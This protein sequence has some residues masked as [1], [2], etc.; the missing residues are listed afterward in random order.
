MNLYGYVGNDPLNKFDPFGEDSFVVARRLDSAFGKLSIGHAF[1]VTN[2]Q[3]IGD[4]NATVHSFGKLIN[5]NMGNITDST[6]AATIGKS[7]FKSDRNA[8]LALSRTTSDNISQINAPD[9]DVDNVVASILE[10][11]PYALNPHPQ[12]L[13][14]GSSFGGPEVV[15]DT[16]V[17]SSSGAFAAGDAASRAA[18]NGNVSREPFTLTLPGASASGKVGTKATGVHRVSGRIESNNLSE[19]GKTKC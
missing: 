3:F 4:P 6:R 15:G 8:W 17:N 1:V 13:R 5:G 12:D 14:N 10:N 7:T 16:S 19:C 11:R 2:A 9:A 18:G